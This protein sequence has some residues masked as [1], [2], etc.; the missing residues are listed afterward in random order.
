MY[1]SRQTTKV[2]VHSRN[3]FFSYCA[4]ARA[5]E[6][7]RRQEFSIREIGLGHLCFR[8]TEKIYSECAQRPEIICRARAREKKKE[9]KSTKGH[10][11]TQETERRFVCDKLLVKD[12]EAA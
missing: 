6:E 1:Q 3:T 12:Q 4:V 9:K 8:R 2:K 10:Q 5:G 7:R 11:M